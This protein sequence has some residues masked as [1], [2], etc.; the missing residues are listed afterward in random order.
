MTGSA[1]DF[2][3]IGIGG[4]Q[5]DSVGGETCGVIKPSVSGE[6]RDGDR[7][8]VGQIGAHV[9]VTDD[10]PSSVDPAS[11]CRNSI[12]R[13]GSFRVDNGCHR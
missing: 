10:L 4:K 3:V 13:S 1:L 8:V 11:N 12:G 9:G 7:M 5:L 2:A 6:V